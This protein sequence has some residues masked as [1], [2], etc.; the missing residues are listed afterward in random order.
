M[1]HIL[2]QIERTAAQPAVGHVERVG[3]EALARFGAEV[4]KA[5]ILKGEREAVLGTSLGGREKDPVE[6]NFYDG[7]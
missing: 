2:N 7:L 1:S 4:E 6:L 5:E 3:I